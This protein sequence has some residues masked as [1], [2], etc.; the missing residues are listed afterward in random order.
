MKTPA[1][2]QQN[3]LA[4]LNRFISGIKK[5]DAY[6]M[7]PALSVPVAIASVVV[8]HSPAKLAVAFILMT[9]CIGAAISFLKTTAGLKIP[10]KLFIATAFLCLAYLFL[11]ITVSGLLFHQEMEAWRQSLLKP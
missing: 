4:E 9:A 8:F 11:E 5:L 3:G 7:V 6:W 10:M 2:L 1:S